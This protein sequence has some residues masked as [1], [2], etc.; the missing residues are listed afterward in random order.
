M[1][2]AAHRSLAG[3]HAEQP[4]GKSG[5]SASMGLRARC[6][7]A[8]SL[9]SLNGIYWCA[10]R[11][12]A[13]SAE[14]ITDSKARPSRCQLRIITDFG[15]CTTRVLGKQS[16]CLQLAR[17]R[18]DTNQQS[19][20]DAGSSPQAWLPSSS[21]CVVRLASR[22][23]RNGSWMLP[24]ME[25]VDFLDLYSSIAIKLCKVILHFNS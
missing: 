15:T 19:R 22:S 20:L 21:S 10:M 2:S 3:A 17:P 5:Q 24:R 14:S 7:A 8:A 16:C 6:A 13:A 11:K 4:G 12:L 23:L 18:R 1:C 9:I 25:E